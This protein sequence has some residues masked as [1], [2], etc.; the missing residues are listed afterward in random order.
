MRSTTVMLLGLTGGIGSGKSTAAEL[1]AKRGAA[2]ID[3]DAISRA[4]TAV[5]GNAIGPIA[6]EFGARFIR[7]DGSLDRDRM[8]AL[9]FAD[10][11]ARARLEAVVHPIVGTEIERQSRQAS[12]AGAH[13]VVIEIPLLVESGRWR[14]R[15]HRTL[16]VDCSVQTQVRRVARRVGMDETQA[17][18]I[19]DVQ[20]SRETRLAA[21]DFVVQNDLDSMPFLERQIDRLAQLL[22]L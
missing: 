1:L 17:M 2:L 14:A 16:T 8:R 21:S 20:A 13:C 10:N 19:V 5:H 22:G 18:R 9:V 12:A 6:I 4:A 11:N 7:Q 3:A 15:L